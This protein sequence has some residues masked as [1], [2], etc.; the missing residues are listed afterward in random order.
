MSDKVI[1]ECK[2]CGNDLQKTDKVCKYCGSKNPYFDPKSLAPHRISL[3]SNVKDDDNLNPSED[4]IKKKK[5][6]RIILIAIAIVII[7]YIF[8][9]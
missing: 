1:M 6:N 5:K 3:L 2:S 7:I 8:L 4:D 9:Q